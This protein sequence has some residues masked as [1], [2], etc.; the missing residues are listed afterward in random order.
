MFWVQIYSRTH[1][2]LLSN[3]AIIDAG[4]MIDANAVCVYEKMK[5]EDKRSE[6][7]KMLHSDSR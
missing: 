5:Y 7:V 6:L 4:E 2:Y 1:A 3:L